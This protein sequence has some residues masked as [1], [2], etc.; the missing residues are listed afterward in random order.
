MWSACSYFILFILTKSSIPEFGITPELVIL[1][2]LLVVIVVFVAA[3]FNPDLKMGYLN[4]N[5]HTSTINHR[6]TNE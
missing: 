6:E 1:S 5:Y 4:T 3:V 2:V